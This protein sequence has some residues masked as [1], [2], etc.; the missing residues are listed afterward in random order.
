LKAASEDFKEKLKFCA[1]CNMT[2]NLHSHL[3]GKKSQIFFVSTGK[4]RT[5]SELKNSNA[6]NTT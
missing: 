2:T 1:L 6:K 3:G 5:I 4:K